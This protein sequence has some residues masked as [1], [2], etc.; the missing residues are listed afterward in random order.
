MEGPRDDKPVAG[1]LGTQGY[2]FSPAVTAVTRSR[3]LSE[4]PA[5][6]LQE[7]PVQRIRIERIAAAQDEEVWIRDLKLFLRGDLS[8]LSAD[9]AMNCG[10]IKENYVLDDDELLLYSPF[11]GTADA[12]REGVVRLVIPESLHQDFLHHYHTSL[13]GSHQGIGRTYQRIRKHFLWKG[14][15]RSVQCFVGTCVDCDTGKGGPTLWGKSPGNIRA[16]YPFQIIAMDHIPSLPRSTNGNTELLIWVDLFTGY[17]IARAS[18]S[19]SAQTVAEGYEESVF[20]RFGASEAIRHDREPSF[21]S[22]FFRAFNRLIGQKQRAT[23]AYRPQANGTAERM[24]QTLTRSIKM[25][26]SHV[27]LEEPRFKCGEINFSAL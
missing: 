25:Y 23:M 17:V 24:V 3:A 5:E 1:A 12:D 19:R 20:R 14:L 9:V 18:A 10:K 22:D 4:V 21:M 15:F 26:V 16:T 27:N 11:K 7:E 6:I 2:Q 13:E 8:C